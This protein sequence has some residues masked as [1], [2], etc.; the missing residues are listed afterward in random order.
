MRAPQP[1][2]QKPA[3]EFYQTPN[4]IRE[5]LCGEPFAQRDG[6][7]AVPAGPSLGVEVDEAARSSLHG[8]RFT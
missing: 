7:V 3:M 8:L 5:M 2:A 4:P 1:F 6:F